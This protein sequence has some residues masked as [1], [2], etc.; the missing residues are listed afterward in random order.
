M[1]RLNSRSLPVLEESLQSFVLETPNHALECNPLRYGLQVAVLSRITPPTAA[2]KARSGF[3]V[4]LAGLVMRTTHVL[5][6]TPGR[7]PKIDRT[8]Q[9]CKVSRD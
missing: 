2:E 1:F 8:C 3:A 9:N 4:P 7:K 5:I 6:F